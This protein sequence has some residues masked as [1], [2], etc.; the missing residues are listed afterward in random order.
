MVDKYE[1]K[2]YISEC[3]GTEYVIP[4]IG[5]PWD[6]FEEIDFDELPDQFV[7]KTTHLQR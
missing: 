6:R 1:V 7:L 3:I 4:S 2:K 5:G